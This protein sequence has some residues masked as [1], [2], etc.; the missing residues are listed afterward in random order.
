MQTRLSFPYL[1]VFLP[2]F[3]VE[4]QRSPVKDWSFTGDLCAKLLVA[5]KTSLE[6]S[7]E[8]GDRLHA[9]E[10][11]LEKIALVRGV[12]GISLETESH[13]ERIDTEYLLNLSEDRDAAA[14]A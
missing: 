1:K 6:V 11:L 2:S 5:E 3:E 8:Q 7:V 4:S 10:K 14:S 13:E 12:D 9:G